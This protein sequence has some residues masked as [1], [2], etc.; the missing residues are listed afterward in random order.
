MHGFLNILS[1]S[2]PLPLILGGMMLDWLDSFTGDFQTVSKTCSNTFP[3]LRPLQTCAGLPWTLTKGTGNV[4]KK[5]EELRSQFLTNLMVEK[6]LEM[7][8]NQLLPQAMHFLLG[9][10]HLPCPQ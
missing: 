3:A 1:T 9:I 4:R 10:L 8:L 6:R 7:I 2:V 5:L